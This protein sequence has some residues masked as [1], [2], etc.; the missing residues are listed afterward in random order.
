M[1]VSV[2]NA[3]YTFRIDHLRKTGA[4]T[5][6]LSVEPLLGPIQTPDQRLRYHRLADVYADAWLLGGRS[7]RSDSRS[8]RGTEFIPDAPRRARPAGVARGHGAV[9]LQAAGHD[10]VRA[11]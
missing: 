3:D 10:P 4:K 11:A 9:G 8:R 5:K 6:F 1:G 7:G 2:E